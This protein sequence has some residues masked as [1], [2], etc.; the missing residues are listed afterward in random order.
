MSGRPR[1]L[2]RTGSAGTE[3]AG[4]MGNGTEGVGARRKCGTA[5]RFVEGRRINRLPSPGGQARSPLAAVLL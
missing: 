2:A 5:G 4:L 1:T 3:G